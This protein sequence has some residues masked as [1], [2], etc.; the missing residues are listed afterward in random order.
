RL[1]RMYAGRGL[2]RSVFVNFG[3]NTAGQ[4]ESPAVA[5]LIYMCDPPAA[6]SGTT[7]C[8]PSDSGS[9]SGDHCVWH[10]L[11]GTGNVFAPGA[12]VVT[13]AASAVKM[14]VPRGTPS[15][16]VTLSISASVI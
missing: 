5:G 4:K 6:S 11:D 16:A 10:P 2:L 1:G 8:A 15:P 13:P 7:C 12:P 3:M 14:P 9:K